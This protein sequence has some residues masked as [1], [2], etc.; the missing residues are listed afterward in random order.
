[1]PHIE[2][3][4]DFAGIRGLMAFRPETA[5][6][7]AALAEVLLRLLWF[8]RIHKLAVRFFIVVNIIKLSSC[9]G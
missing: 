3:N 6:P 7:L 5:E 4:N 9:S 2:V 8:R 1:M